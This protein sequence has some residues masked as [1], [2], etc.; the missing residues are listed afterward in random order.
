MDKEEPQLP[1]IPLLVHLVD[2]TSY[3]PKVVKLESYSSWT[4]QQFRERLA[5]EL[6]HSIDTFDQQCE[7][8]YNR[9]RIEV[10]DQRT[11]FELR[12]ADSSVVT[13]SLLSTSSASSQYST[14]SNSTSSTAG[15]STPTAASITQEEYHPASDTSSRP[16][17]S[18]ATRH[19]EDFDDTISIHTDHSTDTDTLTSGSKY[20]VPELSLIRGVH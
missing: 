4:G 14:Y 18:I 12:I 13:I 3:P 7:V 10:R 20:A 6:G 15:N 19:I 17:I 8:E 16:S 5:T 2:C 1:A 9:I 11:L